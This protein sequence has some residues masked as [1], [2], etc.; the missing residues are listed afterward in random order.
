MSRRWLRAAAWAALP[1][2]VGLGLAALLQAGA[3]PNYLFIGR[4]HADLAALFSVGG[5]LLAG[6]I[7]LAF[8]LRGWVDWRI[9]RLRQAEQ[10]TEA[11][12]RRRFFQRLD[13]ELKN[14]LTVIRL[15]LTN[16][17]Q[18]PAVANDPSLA[19]I[20]QQTQRL[21]KLVK[22]LRALGELEERGIEKTA[23][24]L[25]EV[26]DEAVELA[27]SAPERAD[28]VVDVSVQQ[29]PWPLP[30]VLGDRDLLV[31]LFSNLLDNAFKFTRAGGRVEVRAS[32]DSR[33]AVIEVADNGVGIPAA[34]LEHI[35]EELYRADNA[36]ETPGSG[37][38]LAL[39]QRIVALHGGSIAVRSRQDQGSV[40]TV[41]LPLAAEQRA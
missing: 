39:A 3:L 23:V 30:P 40:V 32:E 10:E 14:P 28:R 26:I 11:A 34:D 1:V 36:R 20:G 24:P 38:G 8:G 37:L 15:G 17:Q 31:V 6:L 2:L 4:Y 35:Y 12:G 9:E 21:Q 27:H 33:L 29:V 25:A 41:R 22:D 18:Q 16:L 13:H 7:G 19:R 5:V